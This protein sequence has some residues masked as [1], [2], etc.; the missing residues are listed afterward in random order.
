MEAVSS[1]IAEVK[2]GALEIQAHMP[3]EPLEDVNSQIRSG[4]TAAMMGP[5]GL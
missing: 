3:N 5:V 1:L 2:C 4:V